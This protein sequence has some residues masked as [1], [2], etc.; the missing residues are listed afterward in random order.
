TAIESIMVDWNSGAAVVKTRTGSGDPGAGR[1]PPVVSTG[2]GLGTVFG[3][4]M[5]GVDAVALPET[6]SAR[7]SQRT[8][9][10]VLDTMRQY[11][12]IHRAAGSVHSCALFHGPDL[13]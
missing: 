13:L 6:A 7:I 8:L 9:Q 5:R 4:V 10:H 2:C 1:L 12:A 3:D 11:D